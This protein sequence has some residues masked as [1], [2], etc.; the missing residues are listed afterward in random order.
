MVDGMINW[1]INIIGK[2]VEGMNDLM[3]VGPGRI[4]NYGSRITKYAIM[5]N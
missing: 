1:M 5:D 3:Y 4:I 2:M